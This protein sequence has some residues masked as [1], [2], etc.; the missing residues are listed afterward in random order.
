MT[1]KVNYFHCFPLLQQQI[2]RV[3]FSLKELSVSTM[4]LQK[5]IILRNIFPSFISNIYLL[6]FCTFFLTER[7]ILI[8]KTRCLY[9][10]RPRYGM[11]FNIG[12]CKNRLKIG[13]ADT[14]LTYLRNCQP[15]GWIDGS[16]NIMKLCRTEKKMLINFAANR[17]RVILKSI[18]K[19][20]FLM[21]RCSVRI[22]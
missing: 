11:S 20:K 16:T 21:L 6:K 7:R 15:N 12:N 9:K 18:T 19:W 22:I 2:H 13:P 14:I 4:T 5:N 8:L 3:D 1:R 10:L 17:K